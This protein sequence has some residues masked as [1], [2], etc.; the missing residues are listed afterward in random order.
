MYKLSPIEKKAVRAAV[1]FM[2]YHGQLRLDEYFE[3]DIADAMKTIYP[4][5]EDE[6]YRAISSFAAKYANETF[7]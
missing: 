3:R 7:D 4:N 6:A 1:D 5:L 2:A